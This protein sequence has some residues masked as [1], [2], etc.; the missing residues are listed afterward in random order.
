M[1]VHRY[2]ATHVAQTLQEGRLRLSRP[3]AFNDPFELGH[4]FT[5]DYQE[6]TV[7]EDLCRYSE[8]GSEELEKIMTNFA[9]DHPELS[10]ADGL[11]R[12]AKQISDSKIRPDAWPQESQQIADEMFRIV[13]F[14]KSGLSDKSEI[15][16]WS[17]YAN[18]HQGFRIEFLFDDHHPSLL[19][20][21][22]Y[23]KKRPAINLN[24]FDSRGFHGD[25]KKTLIT[26]FDAWIYEG[27]IRLV[28]PIQNQQ[29]RLI[30]DGGNYYWEFKPHEVKVVDIGAR[31][32][33]DVEQVAKIIANKYPDALLRH[34][35][36]HPQRFKLVYS[37]V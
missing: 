3:S 6:S 27:E 29:P 4:Q 2:Q 22:Q 5:G 19:E 17:H 1:T 11:R 28:V 9:K 8:Q 30:Q 37:P 10:V 13:C 20:P 12:L 36:E 18:K 35:T 14:S 15:L 23:Q 25:P 33:A 24:E 7:Y 32:T 21:I 31:A 26:K 34:A 16:L